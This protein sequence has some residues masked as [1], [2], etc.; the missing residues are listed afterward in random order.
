M[1]YCIIVEDLVTQ[2]LLCE[3]AGQLIKVVLVK[4]GNAF[5]IMMC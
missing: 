3:S 1:C 5:G 4:A 2:V